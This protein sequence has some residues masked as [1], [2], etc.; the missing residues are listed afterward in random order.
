MSEART[1]RV[2]Q[3][4]TGS[5][6]RLT[7]KELIE[8]PQRE[9]IGVGVH[10]TEK[11]GKDAARLCGLDVATG[12]VATRDLDALLALRPDC[13]VYMGTEYGGRPAGAVTSD[14][15]RILEAGVN[16]VNTADPNLVWPP[17][18]G[19]EDFSFMLERCPGTYAYLGTG[20]GAALHH[21]AY[22]FNDEV[23]HIGASYFARL[24]ERAQ[25]I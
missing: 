17:S 10:S 14:L 11:E 21:P 15:C 23:A 7:L 19:G 8:H 24:V 6:G 9:L 12:V 22:D 13:F 4:G 1:Y 16:V 2:V 20:A 5:T 25:P 3:W 18:M